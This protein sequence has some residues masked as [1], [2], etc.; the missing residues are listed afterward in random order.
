MLDKG[1]CTNRF[2]EIPESDRLSLCRKPFPVTATF[3]RRHHRRKIAH[4][5]SH[6]APVARLVW[7]GIN[8]LT[9]PRSGAL[10]TAA[11]SSH[12]RKSRDHLDQVPVDSSAIRD[13]T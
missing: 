3:S 9:G 7:P 5:L 11:A 8:D 6:P 4:T 2:A 1:H 12:R 10:A 13:G